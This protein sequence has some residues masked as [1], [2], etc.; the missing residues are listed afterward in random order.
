MADRVKYLLLGL[1]FLVVAG[2]IAY[3]RWNPAGDELI[4]SRGTRADEARFVVDSGR[5][6]TGVATGAVDRG[7]NA[8]QDLMDGGRGSAR[9][10][11]RGSLQGDGGSALS[12]LDID[13]GGSTSRKDAVPPRVD[14]APPAQTEPRVVRREPVVQA[15][16]APASAKTHVVQ[17]GETLERIS[18]DYYGTIR[19]VAWIMEANGIENANRIFA[20]QKLVIPAA[21]EGATSTQPVARSH[22][23]TETAASVPSSYVVR[24]GDGDLYAICRRFYGGTG[25]PARVHQVMSL[26]GLWS[27]D[28]AV[29]AR[30]QLPAR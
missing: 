16:P 24:D 17:S 10:E 27:K 23:R 15:P 5:D 4:D 25:L 22:A 9:E 3:D 30:L 12:A 1:L 6:H 18:L 8:Q 11:S 28:V 20:K 26:N 21:R 13:L 19:G 2:V 14:A 7:A 29:G